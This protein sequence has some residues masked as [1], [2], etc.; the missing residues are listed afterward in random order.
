MET[1]NEMVL[2]VATVSVDL[3]FRNI[4]RNIVGT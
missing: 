4:I 3:F 1:T 2:T